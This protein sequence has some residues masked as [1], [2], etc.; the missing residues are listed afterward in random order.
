[1]RFAI[2]A[3][4]VALLATPSLAYSQAGVEYA[5][6]RSDA[7]FTEVIEMARFR[8]DSVMAANNIP[9][10]SV[11]V[12]IEGQVVWSEGFGYANIETGTPV[13]PATKFR[14]G[15]VSKS[16]T[17][18]A[19]GI[20]I[21]EGRLDL[22]VPVQRYAPSFPEKAKGAITSRLVGGHLAGIRHYRGMENFSSRK[23][24]TVTDALGI[25]KNDTLQ[26]PPGEA[27]S[28]SSYGWNLL[29]AVVEGASGEEFL[30]YI[31]G[32]VFGPLD[33]RNTLAEHMDSII[34]ARGAYYVRSGR[35]MSAPIINAPYVDNSYKWAG[36]GFVSTPEDLMKFAHGLMYGDILSEDTRNTLWATQHTSDGEATGYGIGFSDGMEMEHRVVGHGGGSVGGNAW[37]RMFPDDGVAMAVTT[38]ITNGGYGR[39]AA[40]IMMAFLHVKV[41]GG[42]EGIE[43]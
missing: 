13:T 25:F 27:Y 37:F 34:V 26:T 18:V 1:M 17:S 42:L 9:G 6:A 31:Y 11:A 24:L 14:I 16:L 2:R 41:H 12:S 3:L 23:Y 15:S 35:G 7:K 20:L 38:N 29:S 39:V 32:N 30:P 33:M 4:I 21:D 8:F 28:Y 10:L 40:D 22:D 19:M 5:V 36:G 43:H